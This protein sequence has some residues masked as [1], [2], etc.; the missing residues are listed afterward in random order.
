MKKYLAGV[1]MSA[2][3]TLPALAQDE[4]TADTVLATVNGTAITVGHLIA[5]REMLP[6]QYQDLP[7][8]VLFD[9]MLEQLVQQQVLASAAEENLS[10]QGQLGLD[11]ERR[12]Y[13]AATLMDDVGM[14]EVS[15]ND[16]QAEYDA[17]YGSVDAVMEFNASHILVSTEE[18]ALAV[19]EELAAGADFA[20]LARTASEGPSGPNGGQL[21]WFTAGM[22]V[23][24]FE[25]AVFD[26]DV[27]EVSAPVQ[28]QFG[29]HVILLNETRE[30]EPPALAEVS[31]E[32]EE[33]LRRARVDARM[34]ELNEAA[35]IDRPEIEIDPAV[36][37]D[38]GL[39]GE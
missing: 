39:L 37:R 29:W 34:Q 20:E 14:A 9:G 4:V 19:I 30:Q 15:A 27:S 33:G 22:M 35:T 24:D 10:T 28:T 36:V 31:A 8:D 38:I 11:N 16:I 2:L 13:L 32:L 7:D 25:A 1:A 5:M 12:A 17:V 26:L 23:P 3:M 18:A 21:G 6:P